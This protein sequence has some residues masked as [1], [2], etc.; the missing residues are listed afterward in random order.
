[1]PDKRLGCT[2]FRN[3]GVSYPQ[4]GDRPVKTKRIVHLSNTPYNSQRNKDKRVQRITRAL[5]RRESWR[6]W[7]QLE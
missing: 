4:K 3:K 6:T 5:T 7:Y 1:M 2:V